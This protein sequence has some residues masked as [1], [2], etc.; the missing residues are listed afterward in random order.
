MGFIIKME[1][2]DVRSL[3]LAI[4]QT[5]EEKGLPEEKVVEVIEMALAAAYKKEYGKKDERYKAKF[6]REKG[7]A[8]FFLVKKVVDESMILSEEEESSKKESE[9]SEKEESSQKKEE[10]LSQKKVRFNPNRHLM[11]E[12]AKK[13]KK[14]AKPGEDIEFP[15]DEPE[16]FGRIAAQT[17]KQVLLQRLKEAEREEVHSEFKKKEGE[18]VSGVVQREEKGIVFVDVGKTIATMPE[19]EQIK[20]ERY[21]LGSRM[22]FYCLNVEDTPK[23]PEI[24]LSRA[25]PK[26]L[27]KLFE[28]EVPEISSGA[29]DIKSIAREAGSRSKIAVASA[30]EGADAIGSVVGQKGTRVNAVIQELGKEKID[31]VAWSEDPKEFIENALSPAKIISVEIQDNRAKVKIPKD[32]ISLAI[33][34]DGQNV[35]LATELTSWKI[36]VV[37]VEPE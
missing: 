16:Q 26:F 12:E 21:K 1:K 7:K 15:L 36:D 10:P 28:L 23:G 29:V 8:E 30:E 35:R 17:A 37:G 18:I 13:V 5:A 32:Q 22:R 19:K 27:S 6:D 20:G 34:K 33:G 31:I 4:L 3:S 9:S 14:D 2:I 11:L 25:H 24:I